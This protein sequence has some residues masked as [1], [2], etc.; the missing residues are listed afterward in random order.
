MVLRR[1]RLE[2]RDRVHHRRTR[3]P[4]AST[5]AQPFDPRSV[6]PPSQD[7]AVPKTRRRVGRAG[8]N[9]G[10]RLG[11]RDGN[12]DL[13]LYEGRTRMNNLEMHISADWQEGTELTLT[14][15]R[16]NSES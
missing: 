12:A 13:G 11:G 14:L 9:D 5:G 2:K 6:R 7:A 1:A 16:N 15:A 8:S 3:P 4:R 10:T